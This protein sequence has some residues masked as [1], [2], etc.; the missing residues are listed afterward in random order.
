MVN[1]RRIFKVV[2]IHTAKFAAQVA[3]AAAVAFLMSLLW[4]GLSFKIALGIVVNVIALASMLK[5]VN[6]IEES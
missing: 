5:V 2:A 6:A 1:K 4:S 3:V